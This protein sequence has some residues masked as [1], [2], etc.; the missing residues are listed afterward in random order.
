MHNNFMMGFGP[1]FCLVDK[2][3]YKYFQLYTLSCFHPIICFFFFA[4][5]F[6]PSFAFPNASTMYLNNGL[7]LDPSLESNIS[8]SNDSFEMMGNFF[9]FLLSCL[10]SIGPWMTNFL[11]GL[12][13]PLL[14]DAFSLP[15]NACGALLT[16]FDDIVSLVGVCLIAWG[17]S[18]TPYFWCYWLLG[19]FSP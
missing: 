12:P 9:C 8:D 4:W 19:V 18:T 7:L 17:A 3:T 15:L 6:F 16:T 10:S 14:C 5:S 2:Q 1:T 11:L 13:P